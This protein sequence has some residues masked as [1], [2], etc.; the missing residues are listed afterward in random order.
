MA[1]NQSPP[2]NRPPIA[3][4]A[5][6]GKP[7]PFAT[8]YARCTIL[9]RCLTS[10]GATTR[11][12]EPELGIDHP[13]EAARGSEWSSRAVG[14]ATQDSC[15]GVLEHQL[16]RQSLMSWL[17]AASSNVTVASAWR[18]REA[19]ASALLTL[20]CRAHTVAKC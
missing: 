15:G 14:F 11:C 9:S 19:G 12:D 6:D 1:R 13:W 7:G 20:R 4:R 17:P 10:I 8:H 3:T 2:W 16:R 18:R 5:L